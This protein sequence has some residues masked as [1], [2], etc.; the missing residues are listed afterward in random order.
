M[1]WV[2]DVAE[3]LRRNPEIDWKK[4]WQKAD[5]RGA[6]RIMATGLVLVQRAFGV[7]APN[8]FAEHA[9]NNEAAVALADQV[10][11]HWNES[12]GNPE[13]ADLEPSPPWRHRWIIQ[14][15]ENRAQRW[16]YQ[17]RVI[18]MVGEEEFNAIRL[19][20][21]FSPLYKLIRFWNIFRKSR[22][23]TTTATARSRN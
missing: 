21:M 4:F 20:G 11:S 5:A 22:T 15:R 16:A 19:P 23:R 9:Y 7:S 12:I 1:M 8:D 17:R 6:A 14:T 13:L 2:M 10:I 18:L 3:V